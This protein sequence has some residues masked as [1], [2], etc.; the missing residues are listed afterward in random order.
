MFRF[1]AKSNGRQISSRL[2]A[3]RS[4]NALL[5]LPQA[6]AIMPA[7]TLVPALIIA[8]LAGILGHLCFLHVFNLQFEV[9]PLVI[10]IDESKLLSEWNPLQRHLL[11]GLHLD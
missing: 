5:E 7:G 11:F 9:R 2:L 6:R 10:I 4:A 8:D 1:V 3:M